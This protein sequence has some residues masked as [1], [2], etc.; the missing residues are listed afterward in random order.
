M[1]TEK[2]TSSITELRRFIR[3]HEMW[4]L[5]YAS[6][7]KRVRIGKAFKVTLDGSEHFIHFS[8]GES[9][10]LVN[11]SDV[12]KNLFRTKEE[13][14][15]RAEEMRTAIKDMEAKIAEEKK[16]KIKKVTDFLGKFSAWD[17]QDPENRG[18]I[19]DEYKELI[20]DIVRIYKHLSVEN[21]QDDSEYARLLENYIRT[22]SICSQALLFPKSQIA[23]VKC[24]KEGSVEVC[25]TNGMRITPKNKNVA[26]LIK[27]VMGSSGGWEYN[28]IMYPEGDHDKVVEK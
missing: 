16:E 10:E 20:S 2:K 5:V 28:S 19:K 13:A 4:Y 1:A 26:R 14:K 8:Y 27:V 25:L 24:G 21:R 12:K 3:T 9:P 17:M 23:S 6:Y 15:A 11:S 18:D 22:G 7:G